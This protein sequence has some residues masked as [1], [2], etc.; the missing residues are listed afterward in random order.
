VGDG[1]DVVTGDVEPREVGGKPFRIG[2]W[3]VEPSLNRLSKDDTTIQLEL[4]V[5]DVLV[6]LAERAGE[7][8]PRQ[9]I[10][11]RVWATEFISDNTLTHAITE[12]RNALGDDARNPSFIETIHR[13]GYRL[14]APVE[15]TVS[16]E[17]GESKVARFPV[18]ERAVS[19]EVERSPYPGLAAFTE[20]DAEFFFGREAEVALMWR[21][22][23]SRKLL[24]VIGPSGVGK[25]SFLRAGVIPAR[26]EGWGVLVCQPGEAPF[27]AL[28]RTLVPDFAGDI[29]ALA[30]LVDIRDGDRAIAMVSR[31]RDRQGQALLIVD[32]FEELFTQNP[33]ETQAA[34][35]E[36]LR[37]LVDNGDVHVLL[38]MRDDFLFKCHGHKPLRPVFDA[39]MPLEQPD[40]EALSQALVE[41]ARRLGFAFEDKDLPGEMI[42]GVEGE[43]GALP[44]LAFA[45]ARLWDKRDADRRLLTNRAYADIGGVGGA[46]AG[47][48]EATLK[49]IGDEGVP[50]VR[51]IFRNLV[52][53]EGTRAV[54][55]SDDLLTV[56][57]E[58]QQAKA[59]QVLR[60]LVDARLLTSFEEEDVE[61]DGRRRV[62][63]VH[64][65]LLSSWPRLVRWQTQDA[66]SARLRDQL[67]QAA[68]TWDEQGRTDDT[69]WTG[70][71]YREYSV[72]RENYPGGLTEL[73]EDYASA[74]ISH[75]KRRKR[76][77][78]IAVAAVLV[79][80]AVVA[81]VTTGLWRRSVVQER[82]AEAQKLIALGQVQ[83]EDYPTAALAYATQSLELAD[84]EEARFLALEA[85]WEGPTAFIVNEDPTLTASFSP[86]GSWLVQ[87]RDFMSSLAIISRDG[88]QRVLDHPTDSGKTRVVALFGGSE[89]IFLSWGA[90]TDAGRIAL[91]SASEGRLLASAKPVNEPALNF[92][93]GGIGANAEN[94]RGL[95]ILPKDGLVTIAALRTD[96]HHKVLGTLRVTDPDRQVRRGGFCMPLASGEWLGLV[97]G[98][99][100]SI[101]R[102]GRNGLS[103]QLP[104]GRH[105]GDLYPWCEADHLGRFLVT[106]SRSGEIVRWDLTGGRASAN[107]RDPW[108]VGQLIDIGL[109][110]D[111]PHLVMA[112]RTSQENVSDVWIWSVG[113][114]AIRLLRRIEGVK[115]YSAFGAFDPVGLQMAMANPLPVNRLW[116]FAAPAG[117]EPTLLRRGPANFASFSGFSPD[118]RWLATC[119]QSGLMMWPLVRPQAAVIRL[120][121]R[122]WI[123]GVEFGP[124]GRFLTTSADSK[125]RLWPLEGSVPPA[126]HTVFEAG[127]LLSG[128]AVS[129]NGERFAVGNNQG[130]VWIGRDDGGEPRQLPGSEMIGARHAAFSPDGRFVASLTGTYDMKTAVARVWDVESSKEIAVLTLRD[131]E[132]RLGSSFTSDG[133]LL[134]GT[135]KGVVAWDVETGDHETLADVDVGDFVASDDGRHVLVTEEGEAGG[136]Q[137]PAGPPIFFDLDT[138]GARSLATHGSR[139]WSMALDRDGTVAVTGDRDG[140]VRVGPVTGEKPHLLLGHDGAVRDVAVD[141]LGRW[142]ASGGQDKTLRL[143]PMP[144]LSKP[145]LHTLPREELIAKLKT[146]TNLRVVRD[147]ESS[148]GW[149]VEIGP[150]PGWETVPTW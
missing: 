56:F 146:L 116:S 55:E 48:A 125:V 50:I 120:D 115:S 70:A 30:Q 109:S 117:A 1:A 127:T 13:R 98:R 101:V 67:R 31:W 38:S 140:I 40:A 71:A 26:P 129:P 58:S 141:P 51:E 78:R 65:T 37:K 144:D 86:G 24:A 136:M 143:W 15:A 91:W 88:K 73:E 108:D 128:V 82:R 85:L 106:L 63:V 2:R 34:V 150:F 23:T 124:E 102:V 20:D 92:Y 111:P 114:D 6:C 84:S 35:A 21:K 137:D 126:G 33:P 11:D 105:E 46:L 17:A 22:L 130:E 12:L 95:F 133:R 7:V 3:L 107:V 94:P 4:K 118:G 41:P 16:D 5:M 132:F 145:P 90:H 52:T 9:E 72:W 25:S 74:M 62:E 61:G 113:E 75:A 87:A 27:P 93:R 147:E 138:G 81:T 47:H 64:E 66:D 60:R 104:L 42:A 8:V 149:K 139:V 103:D 135:S 100:V 68:R 44:M 79:L 69:L 77:R 110:P 10:V 131:D 76:R 43:R 97:E 36:M 28:A 80:A 49:A 29:E 96:G 119:D 112:F 89:D 19:P 134:T 59:D 122:F 32:Q 14:I 53:A 39:L 57:P 123:G 18:R 142:I 83:L 99:K 54:R 121:L 148:T 45:V